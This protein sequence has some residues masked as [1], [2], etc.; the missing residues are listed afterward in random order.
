LATE[1]N[2]IFSGGQLRKGVKFLRHFKLLT[3]PHLRSVADGLVKPETNISF[4]QAD[5]STPED[6]ERV[7]PWNVGELTDLDAA[8]CPR[9]FYWKYILL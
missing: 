6:E 9:R 3:R 2:K 1:F 5:S 8:V 4:Y 7:R